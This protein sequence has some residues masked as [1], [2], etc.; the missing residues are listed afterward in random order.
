MKRKELIDRVNNVVYSKFNVDVNSI[1]PSSD[2]RDLLMKGTGEFCSG[3]DAIRRYRLLIGFLER[4]FKLCLDWNLK[5]ATFQD[6]YCYIENC[7]DKLIPKS[8]MDLTPKLRFLHNGSDC[9]VYPLIS[10]S[11]LQQIRL[12]FK[13]DRKETII[14]FRDTSTWDSRDQGLVI[15]NEG[16]YCINDN[17]SNDGRFYVDWGEVDHVEYQENV[18][19]FKDGNN[20]DYATYG[21]YSFAKEYNESTGP[22][23]ADIFTKMA[24]FVEAKDDPLDIL[25]AEA[26]QIAEN[27]DAYGAVSKLNSVIESVP[28]NVKACLYFHIADMLYQAGDYKK[29]IHNC[30]SGIELCEPGSNGYVMLMTIR[31]SAMEKQSDFK[32][33]RK[34]CLDVINYATDQEWNG[35]Y[36]KQIAS[37]KFQDLDENYSNQFLSFPYNERKVVMP[38]KEYTNLNQEH[39]AVVNMNNLP[40]ISFPVGHPIANQVYVGHPLIP[41]EYIPFEKYQLEFVEDKI[42]EFCEL[43]ESL[44]ATEITI[45]C[46]NSSATNGS[47]KEQTNVSGEAGNKMIKGSGSAQKESSQ[48]IMD[49]I[50]QSI[51]LHQIFTPFNKPRVPE[52]MVWYDKEPSWQRL[53]SQRLNGGLSSHEERIETR[54]SQMVEGRELIALK[55]EINSL[56]ADMKVSED[57]T[58]ESKFDQKENVVLAIKVKFAPI[59]QLTGSGNISANVSSNTSLTSAEEEYIAELKDILAEGEITPRERRLLEKI[60]TQLGIS[61]SRAAELED[62]VSSI[63]LTPEEQEYFDEYSEIIADGEISDRDQR[64][65]EKLKKANSI[66]EE[67]AKEIEALVSSKK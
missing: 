21:I 60:R 25:L 64:F 39:I 53:V 52:N 34:D 1:E 45:D 46:L 44:G 8:I 43:A 48:Q 66:S 4:E 40:S 29:T 19:Y 28:D 12:S 16:L 10:E 26:R 13:I 3:Y 14:L 35:E 24:S 27:G 36:C 51:K 7:L 58:E 61:E 11:V 50:S 15:T 63:S 9:L 20:D 2:I 30:N 32:S 59:S 38:V 49:E 6:L 54:K 47:S 65:L 62:S 33:A 57:K 37:N 22:S 42:R 41:S 31:L 56:Y 18:L 67:R 17:E 23:L 55:G 5:M